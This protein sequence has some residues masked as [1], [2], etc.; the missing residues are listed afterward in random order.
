MT[1]LTDLSHKIVETKSG[2]RLSKS[3]MDY[4]IGLKNA[5]RHCEVISRNLYKVRERVYLISG[6]SLANCT[7]IE[8]ESGL[9][10]FDTGNNIGQG[11]EILEK[12][13]E[14]SD[15]PIRAVIYSHHHYTGGTRLFVENDQ[16]EAC[17]IYGHPKIERNRQNTFLGFGRM[18]LR[19]ISMQ[20][21]QYLTE[22]G[23]DASMGMIEP[24]YED[25]EL[26]KN[27]HLPVTHEVADQEEVVI[28]GLTAR[29]YHVVAD[30]D[31]SLAVWFPELDTVLHNA[32]AVRVFHPF[33]TLR[34]DFYRSPE[35]AIKGIDVMRNIRP[36]YL[37]GCHGAPFIGREETY[38]ALTRVRD[39][40]AFLY[41]QAVRAINR[42]LSPDQMVRDIQ[43]P[44]HLKDDP[45]L[46]EGYVRTD[47]V[48]RGF[49]RGIV[50][51]FA[52]DTA[53]LNP[54]PPE[55]LAREIVDGFGG[56]DRVIRRCLLLFEHHKFELAAKLITYVLQVDPENPPARQLKADALRV[57]AQLSPDI[58]SRHFYLTQALS[59]EKKIDT[60]K[61]PA[62]KFMGDQGIDD[63]LNT[64]PGT[65]I[66]L[67]ANMIDPQKSMGVEKS[68]NVTFTDLNQ[69]FGLIVRKGV[70][71]FTER[72]VEEA[73]FSL[74]L[75]RVVWLKIYFRIT[76]LKKVVETGEAKLSAG[77]LPDLEDFLSLFDRFKY[78]KAELS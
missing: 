24:R 61:P 29:F 39:G 53:D 4:F 40:Y 46:Y 43:L 63:L 26:N 67:L 48:I 33:Y 42:G 23:E 10:V 78:I 32:A 34:G 76:T 52:E 28:D 2:T 14:V 18:Q 44:D 20:A 74:D 15:K 59:L 35:G 51:W 62:V 70:T 9:I 5:F 21:G 58:Q 55:I 71:E 13:R 36:E 19:R 12:I 16:G 41:Q 7:F 1:D 47:Y 6:F 60:S 31:D 66:K 22:N 72:A 27:G 49:Y 25:P 65:I 54:P 3:L 68:L 50:G 11:R 57:M 45:L 75:T 64:R 69:G 30:T 17:A 37:I 8:G 77:T 73:D 56:P 38:Q